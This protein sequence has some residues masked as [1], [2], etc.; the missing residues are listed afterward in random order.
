[1]AKDKRRIEMLVA[2]IILV[3]NKRR[4][5]FR[6]QVRIYDNELG[7]LLPETYGHIADKTVQ[8]KHIFSWTFDEAVIV[9]NRL[10][11]KE[12]AFDFL[13][14]YAPQKLFEDDKLVE[15]LISDME[16]SG[17]SFDKFALEVYPDFLLEKDSKAFQNVLALK[18]KGVRFILLH[19]ASEN[20]PISK[21]SFMPA[22]ILCIDKF[23][24]ECFD[25]DEKEREYAQSVTN[26]SKNLG[27]QILCSQIDSK[28]IS[29]TLA[30]FIDLGS[31]HFFG[32][33][34]NYKYIKV[35]WL[36]KI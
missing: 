35:R 7:V 29:E 3:K 16:N 20:F 8:C 10:T 19:F 13:S 12:I 26:M 36:E 27:K 2:P 34:G 21:I 14:F 1:M 31:G 11:A 24:V 15:K 32:E 5:A 22:D 30:E 6:S 33:F 18:E 9:M 25:G 28:Q 4:V 23:L 17:I